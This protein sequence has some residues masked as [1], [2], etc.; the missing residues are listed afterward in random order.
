MDG[1]GP[2]TRFRIHAQKWVESRP[3]QYSQQTGWDV[4]HLFVIPLNSSAR[5]QL[6]SKTW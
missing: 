2:G 5:L 6:V 3:I 4:L 1:M